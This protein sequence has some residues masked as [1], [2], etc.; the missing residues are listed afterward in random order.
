MKGVGFDALLLCAFQSKNVCLFEWIRINPLLR[1]FLT[2]DTSF[3]HRIKARAGDERLFDEGDS[4][5]TLV[6][7]LVPWQYWRRVDFAVSRNGNCRE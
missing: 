7:H 1:D 5:E 6:L 2:I 4:D 3:C